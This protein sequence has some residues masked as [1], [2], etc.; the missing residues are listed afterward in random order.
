MLFKDEDLLFAL[1]HVNQLIIINENQTVDQLMS[2]SADQLKENMRLMNEEMNEENKYDI[3]WWMTMYSKALE[4]KETGEWMSRF[5]ELRQMY[6]S[7]IPWAPHI[8]I[9]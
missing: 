7:V 8:V 3:G 4:K 1:Q 6:G 9:R 2:L 5:Q